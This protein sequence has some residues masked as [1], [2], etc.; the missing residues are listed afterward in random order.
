VN[1]V[2]SFSIH[3]ARTYICA[4]NK[5]LVALAVAGIGNSCACYPEEKRGSCVIR[6][7]NK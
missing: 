4:R 7:M 5:G 1:V 3:R 2:L 6:L